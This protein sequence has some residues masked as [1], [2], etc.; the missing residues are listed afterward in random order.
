MR[1]LAKVLAW[2]V[3]TPIVVL[4]LS[5]GGCEARKAY[6][7]WQVRKMCEKDGG[8][9]VYERVKI[10]EQEYKRLRGSGGQIAVPEER[11]APADYPYVSSTTRTPIREGSPQVWRTEARITR[12]ADGKVLAIFITY[13]RVGGDFPS[14]AHPSYKVC[15][16]TGGN[17]SEQVF[18]VTGE[19][20]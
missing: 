11:S 19:A 17:V 5:I 16:L 10:S 6:Y 9:T 1:A 4:A 14:W 7:D 20:K 15:E 18:T 3:L 8:V 2:V 13:S 12:R